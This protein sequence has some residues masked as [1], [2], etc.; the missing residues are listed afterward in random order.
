MRQG[1]CNICE[2][3]VT[4]TGKYLGENYIGRFV[5]N[6]IFVA[7]VESMRMCSCVHLFLHK[8]R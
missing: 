2:Y 7:Q 5:F 8:N 6:T 4:L 1:G 3:S